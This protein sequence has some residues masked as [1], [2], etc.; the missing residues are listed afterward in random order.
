MLGFVYLFVFIGIIT[1]WGFESGKTTST[2]KRK[3]VLSD[4][5]S[6]LSNNGSD[7]VPEVPLSI[8]PT[9]RRAAMA[10]FQNHTTPAPTPILPPAYSSAGSTEQTTPTHDIQERL[11]TPITTTS[12]STTPSNSMTSMLKDQEGT[13][14]SSMVVSAETPKQ[15]QRDVTAALWHQVLWSMDWKHQCLLTLRSQPP[16]QPQQRLIYHT[17]TLHQQGP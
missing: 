16:I 3:I 15:N 1:T 14:L 9:T 17:L 7:N 2:P 11:H 13:A 8:S 10:E 5:T 4:T 6:A 12:K